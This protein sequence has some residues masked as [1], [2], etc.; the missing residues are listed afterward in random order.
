MERNVST[1]LIPTERISKDFPYGLRF[2]YE[3]PRLEA[4]LEKV[5]IVFPLLAVPQREKFL[6]VSGHKRFSYCV[7][8]KW[9]KVPVTLVEKE[10]SDKELFLLSLYSNWNQTF[11][12]LDQMTAVWKA[13]EIFK[14]EEEDLEEEV[15]PALGLPSPSLLEDLG[16]VSGLAEEIHDLIHS[17]KL[18]FRGTAALSSFSKEEQ[19][20]LARS[21][22]E[23]AHWTTNQLVL[24]SEWLLDIKKSK[25][26][27]LGEVITEEK[28][29]EILKSPHLDPR[30]RGEKLFER[31]RLLRFPALS[32]EEKNFRR[33]KSRLEETKE[34]RVEKPEG[35]E[36]EG[37]L[38]RARLRNREGLTRVLQ[39]LK[40]HR[41]SLESLL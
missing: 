3:D 10:F 20:L 13:R 30:S 16:R 14:M 1:K 23:T 22:F 9:D 8:M 21:F 35:L 27:S 39:F 19:R 11:S 40:T 25:K 38:L 33:L 15:L 26:I 32:Q 6:L 17:G 29:G 18:P 7:R 37:V 41:D 2:R 12:D 36:T 5:G 31:V 34:I 4:S 28:T 24:V